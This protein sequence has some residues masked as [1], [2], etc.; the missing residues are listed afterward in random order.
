MSPPAIRVEVAYAAPGGQALRRLSLPE[1]A[2]VADAV[3][4]SG[5]AFE[6][7]EIDLAVNRVGIYG[8]RVRLDTPLRDLDRVEIL[9]PL[10]ADP[11][12]IRRSRAS[13]RRSG[14]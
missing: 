8:R 10:R 7:P 1:G 5:L 13:G 2:S 12:E 4:E 6:F 9:R 11:K 3:R 14:R